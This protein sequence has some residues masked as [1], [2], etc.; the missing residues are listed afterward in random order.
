MK[1]LSSADNFPYR[2]MLPEL[3][4]AAMA[5]SC[6]EAGV[7]EWRVRK[8]GGEL[9]ALSDGVGADE[10]TGGYG[11]QVDERAGG[12][13]GWIDTLASGCAGGWYNE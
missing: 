1:Y 3:T 6:G 12:W 9:A 13:V 5:G 2:A 8:W 4:G 10:V 11:T 7:A